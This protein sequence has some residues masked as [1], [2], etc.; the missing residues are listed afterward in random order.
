MLCCH[1]SS[2]LHSSLCMLLILFLRYF[3]VSCVF[4]SVSSPCCFV[5]L[6]WAMIMASLWFVLFLLSFLKIRYLHYF[7]PR[8]FFTSLCVCLFQYLCLCVVCLST[9][10]Y[11]LFI[12]TLSPSLTLFLS[13]SP[14][15]FFL[16]RSFCLSACLSICLLY[17]QSTSLVASAFSEATYIFTCL[18]PWKIIP[19]CQIYV[20][21]CFTCFLCLW[22]RLC[23]Q[24][25]PWQRRRR[26]LSIVFSNLIFSNLARKILCLAGC[27]D[28][29]LVT[30]DPISL[31]HRWSRL[32]DA[33][34]Y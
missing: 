14:Y 24:H 23:V 5:F 13:Y 9:L 10:P 29:H 12:P 8:I 11:A 20:D 3:F 22:E 6:F 4:S 19:T 26:R 2:V 7:V 16:F 21:R 18:F 33:E 1:I 31:T 17:L 34:A 30:I 15:I 27:H 32:S 25:S 28:W